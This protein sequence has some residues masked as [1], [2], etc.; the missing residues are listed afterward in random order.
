MAKIVGFICT[1]HGPQRTIQGKFAGS[2]I[3]VLIA[4]RAHRPQNPERPQL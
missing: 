1:A 4:S 2:E 3:V